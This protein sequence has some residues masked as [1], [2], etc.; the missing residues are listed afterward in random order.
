MPA[1]A[2][3]ALTPVFDARLPLPF[4]SLNAASNS[5]IKL[6]WIAVGTSDTRLGVNRQ[7][8]EFLKSRGITF[9]YIEFPGEGHLWPPWR[10]NFAEFGQ[11]VFK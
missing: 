8:T 7:F 6:L 3:C 1:V 4:P 5:R 2:Q 10:K 11:L 9:T